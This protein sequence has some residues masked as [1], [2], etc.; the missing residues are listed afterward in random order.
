MA[1]WGCSALRHQAHGQELAIWPCRC[2]L[3][4]GSGLHLPESGR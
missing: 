4:C 3:R 1:S 2:A